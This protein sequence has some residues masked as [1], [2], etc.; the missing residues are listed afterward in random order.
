MYISGIF[1]PE[2]GFGFRMML[3]VILA[4]SLSRAVSGE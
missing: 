3:A 2:A 4:I 1:P